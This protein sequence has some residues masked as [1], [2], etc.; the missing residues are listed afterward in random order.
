MKLVWVSALETNSFGVILGDKIHPG[1]EGRVMELTRDEF[2]ILRLGGHPK[3][4]RVLFEGK[5]YDAHAHQVYCRADLE[6]QEVDEYPYD[7]EPIPRSLRTPAS[8]DE[9]GVR[10]Y[11]L[12]I[13][14][15]GS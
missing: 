3:G 10:R 1:W 5:L 6:V 14:N 13:R 12:L 11:H 8:P 2:I 7:F 15:R 9:H 4:W